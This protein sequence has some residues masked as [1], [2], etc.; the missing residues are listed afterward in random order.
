MA[1]SMNW[2]LLNY[3]LNPTSAE[4]SRLNYRWECVY[5]A[6]KGILFRFKTSVP[7]NCNIL[8]VGFVHFLCFLYGGC[9]SY[10]TVLV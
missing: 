7:Q 2:L 9:A 6:K 4:I 1:R 5:S 10:R 8:W 3:R